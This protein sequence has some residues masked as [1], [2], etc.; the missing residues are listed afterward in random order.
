MI[1]S[2]QLTYCN[3]LKLQ[4]WYVHVVQL[5][6]LQTRTRILQTQWLYTVS[7]KNVQPLTCYN[8]YIHCSIATIFGKNVAE[9]ADNQNVRCFPTSPN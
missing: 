8:L 9:K 7:Q 4:C 1:L 2:F 5:L 3:A 6:L